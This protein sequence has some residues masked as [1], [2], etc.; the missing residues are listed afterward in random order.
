MS[1]HLSLPVRDLE[2]SRK[3]YVEVL[4][5]KITRDEPAYVNFDL[6]GAQI[7]L[8]ERRNMTAPSPDMHF[9]MNLSVERFKELAT[10]IEQVAAHC[11]K[12][13][14]TIVEAGTARERH[15]MF[16]RCPSGY[17]IEVKGVSA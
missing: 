13:K 3:F 11:V 4:Q 7:T 9:G 15:K 8:H 14:P 1:F 6:D 12:V 16:I 10:H 2:E 17:S 5:A